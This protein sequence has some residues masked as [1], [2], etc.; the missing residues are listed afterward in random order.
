LEIRGKAAAGLPRRGWA[1]DPRYGR[2]AFSARFLYLNATLISKPDD[3]FSV[4][5][6]YADVTKWRTECSKSKLCRFDVIAAFDQDGIDVTIASRD[7][8][9]K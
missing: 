5:D 9:R 1:P 3:V 7:E 2:D 4:A 6:H 8:V